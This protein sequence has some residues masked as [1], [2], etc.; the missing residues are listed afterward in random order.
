M[1]SSCIESKK[2]A[3]LRCTKPV[4]E[5]ENVLLAKHKQTMELVVKMQ[6]V[7][8]Y[9]C[10]KSRR[11]CSVPQCSTYCEIENEVSLHKFP[12]DLNVRKRWKWILR[13]GKPISKYML[14][15]SK[16]FRPEDFMPVTSTTIKKRL[17]KGVLPSQHIPVRPHDTAQNPVQR[18]ARKSLQCDNAALDIEVS[19]TMTEHEDNMETVDNVGIVRKAFEISPDVT[20]NLQCPST[21]SKGIQ[22]DCSSFQ[23]P[24]LL[25]DDD[26]LLHFTVQ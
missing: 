12:D 20:L 19:Q 1:Y 10:I 25:K 14:V 7:H 11:I 4:Q 3:P 6:K 15:C 22:T 23:L 2:S 18:G 17:K 13:I 9:K 5:P 26:K 21:A 24:L 16:H 8:R